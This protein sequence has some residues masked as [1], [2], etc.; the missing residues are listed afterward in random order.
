MK[1]EIK[2]E[3]SDNEASYT[4]FSPEREGFL[5]KQGGRI[6]SWKRRNFILTG[7]CLYYFKD[8]QDTTPCG[9][10][11]LE[12]LT[13][14][15]LEAGGGYKFR[16]EVFNPNPDIKGTIKAAK[17][18]SEGKIIE[19]RHNSYLFASDSQD[20]K[21]DWMNSIKANMAKPPLYA[22]LQAK[23]DKVVNQGA[24]E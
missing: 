13:V 22:L 21:V 6:K 11:P 16:F 8:Q 24:E 4:F 3:E 17:T 12:N 2:L 14:R 18:N 23:R 20:E 1:E 19:G 9:I 5:W 15:D 10:I 7:N